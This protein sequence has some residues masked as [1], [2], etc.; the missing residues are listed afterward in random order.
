ML[1]N[2]QATFDFTTWE[3]GAVELSQRVT[4]EN[5]LRE[6]Q[7]KQL[8]TVMDNL[9]ANLGTLQHPQMIRAAERQYAEAEAEFQRL[10][11]EIANQQ[12]QNLQVEQIRRL[13]DSCGEIFANW[14]N[15]S[16]DEQREVIH[17][18]VRRV[19]ATET[20]YQGLALVVYW[21][22]GGKKKI[23]IQGL[24]RGY[25]LWTQEEINRVVELMSSGAKQLE[26]CKALP[27]RS[28][29]SIMQHYWAAVPKENRIKRKPSKPLINRYETYHEYLERTGR[30]SQSD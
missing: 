2:I 5:M 16:R 4:E 15:M 27:D 7:L 25:P 21:T 26:V 13:R 24:N 3:E 23:R 28:W 12:T 22:D 11:G 30:N 14:P 10:Q 20:E 17:G 6:S 18:F 19:E 1:E 29:D 9:L 8:Q